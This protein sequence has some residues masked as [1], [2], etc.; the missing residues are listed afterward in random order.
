M[1]KIILKLV[2]LFL[3]LGN[4]TAQ[5]KLDNNVV[6]RI[7]EIGFHNS[8]IMNTLIY[9]SDIC[10]PRLSGTSNYRKAAE[11][12]KNKLLSWGLDKV[13]LEK[14]DTPYP[15]WEVESFSICMIEPYYSPIIGYPA[16]WT[17]N[18]KT[19]VNSV[20]LVVDFE[21]IETLKKL[22][23][24]L[25]GKILLFPF[26]ES[27]KITP[28]SK[29][30]NKKI[31]QT[32][33]SQINL[34]G[35]NG[36]GDNEPFNLKE[37]ITENIK[38]FGKTS[39]EEIMDFLI[40]QKVA[41][42]LIPSSVD[43][44]ILKVRDQFGYYKSGSA[45]PY[46]II[47]KEDH[48]RLIRMLERGIKPKISIKQKTRFYNQPEN[49]VNVVGEFTGSDKKEEIVFVGAHLDSWHVGTGASDN[50]AGVA[51]MMEA[52]R[53]L[54][55][56]NFRPL[57]TIKIGLWGG[58]EQLFF[59]SLGYVQKH[60]GKRFTNNTNSKKISI[61]LNQDSGSGKIRGVYL[62]GN[63]AVRPFFEDCFKPFNYLGVKTISSRNSFGTD[64]NV[65]NLFNIP[66]FEFIQDPDLAENYQYHSNLDVVDLIEEDN[67]KLNSV[68]IATLIY[69]AAMRDEMFP[70]KLLIK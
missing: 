36:L 43:N 41:A 17:G 7:K 69:Q 10:G 59:G 33:H 64:H 53:I 18:T 49:N 68:V 32:T 11:W 45:I 6:A 16:A 34:F 70:R 15:G 63:E 38:S 66:A 1:K 26:S 31:L 14:F 42:V 44:G 56:L 60:F 55:K 48:G 50:A 25:E 9:L 46:I 3:I 12:A 22:S 52:I 29:I 19:T 51:V 54:K 30:Y 58:E 2:F 5:E 62:H 4:L 65:F 39:L 27:R 24:K 35:N 13:E 20:P 28:K 21:N 47:S 67:L 40:D 37:I 61:Y 8:E 57:R 23:G